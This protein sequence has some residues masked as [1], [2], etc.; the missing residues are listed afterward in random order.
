MIHWIYIYIYIYIYILMMSFSI[1]TG[2][3]RVGIVGSEL[4]LLLGRSADSRRW[5]PLQKQERRRVGG[6]F[7]H[8][9]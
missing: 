2:L 9:R 6:G 1:G 8:G 5:T 4:G 3:K 7:A